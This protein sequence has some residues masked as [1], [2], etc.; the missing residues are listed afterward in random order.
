MRETKWRFNSSV[1]LVSYHPQRLIKP[2]RHFLLLHVFFSALRPGKLFDGGLDR[3]APLFRLALHSLPGW[4]FHVQD[5]FVMQELI[6]NS[7]SC[8]A[9]FGVQIPGEQ[10][11]YSKTLYNTITHAGGEVSSNIAY[12]V[13]RSRPVVQHLNSNLFLRILILSRVDYI[14][15]WLNDSTETC[16]KSELTYY[17]AFTISLSPS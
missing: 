11:E 16:L 5:Q 17:I 7:Y 4:H 13:S 3:E 12:P 1:A 14:K 9:L 10:A 8:R 2:Q 15:V 6:N